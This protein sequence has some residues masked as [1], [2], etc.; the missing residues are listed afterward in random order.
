MP[1]TDCPTCG[2]L[3]DIVDWSQNAE[4]SY[5]GAQFNARK[6]HERQM[7]ERRKRFE[8]QTG[9]RPLVERE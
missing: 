2:R 4:C 1:K 6:N 9:K 7:A 3:A 5:C 8:Q